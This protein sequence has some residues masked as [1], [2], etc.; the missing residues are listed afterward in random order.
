MDIDK[1][2]LRALEALATVPSRDQNVRDSGNI[3]HMISEIGLDVCEE[4]SDMWFEWPTTDV[5]PIVMKAI[6]L[7]R[8]ARQKM[9]IRVIFPNKHFYFAGTEADVVKRLKEHMPNQD[10]NIDESQQNEDKND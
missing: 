1:K 7:G 2:L 8:L 3:K 5:K 10:E 4:L 9:I 6:L